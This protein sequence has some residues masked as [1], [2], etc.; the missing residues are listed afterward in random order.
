MGIVLIDVACMSDG[1]RLEQCER[2]FVKSTAGS[3]RGKATESSTRRHLM[4]RKIIFQRH[5]GKQSMDVADS[6]TWLCGRV[7]ECVSVGSLESSRLLA[8]ACG[9]GV[10]WCC[11]ARWATQGKRKRASLP[12]GRGITVK[13]RPW[14]DGC[15][16]VG[17]KKEQV[18]DSWNDW[19]WE[20]TAWMKTWLCLILEG[21]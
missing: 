9:A 1:G 3:S 13:L 15:D 19:K 14:L 11:H 4:R 2:V 6:G 5:S 20:R 7:S 16:E 21:P 12:M 8:G 18:G 17:C 10:L